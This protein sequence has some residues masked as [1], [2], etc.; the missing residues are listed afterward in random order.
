MTNDEARKKP[1]ARSQNDEMLRGVEL[2]TS[3]IEFSESALWRCVLCFFGRW[4]TAHRAV[5]T[6]INFFIYELPMRTPAAKTRAPP[7]AIWMMAEVRGV[8]MKRWRTQEMTPSSMRTTMTATHVA[9]WMFG[10]R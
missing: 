3:N 4:K 1:E 2:S 10:M 9:V 5:A 8:S 6:T 7:N